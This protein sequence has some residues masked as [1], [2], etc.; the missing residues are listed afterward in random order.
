VIFRDHNS[1]LE[2]I[3]PANEILNDGLY[4]EL[5]A[6]SAHVFL[7]FRQ[8]EDDEYQSYRHINQYLAGRGVPDLQDALRELLVQPV[9]EPFRQIANTGYWQYLNAQL[10]RS[11]QDTVSLDLLSEASDKFRK[12]INGMHTLDHSLQES[13]EIVAAVQENLKALLTLPVLTQKTPFPGSR[14]YTRAF[15]YVMGGLKANPQRWAVWYTWAFLSHL[16]DLADGSNPEMQ[17]ISWLDEFQLNKV[18]VDAFQVHGVDETTVYRH[19]AALRLL[20]QQQHWY[21]KLGN[22]PLISILEAWLSTNEIR[23]FLNI[24]RHQDILWFNQEAFEEFLWWMMV[25]AL[26]EGATNP[27]S[28]SAVSIEQTL[29]AYEIVQKLLKAEKASDFQVN[30]LL[31]QTQKK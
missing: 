3:R 9:M 1:N 4:I 23:Y 5:R 24:N 18:L 7:D 8:V 17:T 21:T 29:G 28:N 10:C 13:P 30:K 31:G 6:Y 25:V 15:N 2:Y 20:I 26:V 27:E 14:K 16:G 19:I 11:A 22:S 12:L